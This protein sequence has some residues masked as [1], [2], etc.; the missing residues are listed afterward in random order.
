MLGLGLR[1]TP[2]GTKSYILVVFSEAPAANATIGMKN[3]VLR[4][5]LE[6]TAGAVT[7]VRRV[8]GD[9]VHRIVTVQPDGRQEVD[10][11]LP[12]SPDCGAAGAICTGAGG[13]LETPIL[14]RVR[15]PA[16]L[17]VADARVHE[18]PGATL[19]FAVTLGRA[20]S[21]TVV[22]ADALARIDELRPWNSKV[23]SALSEIV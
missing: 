10:I 15:G 2:A 3:R 22:V 1:V 14:T 23:D 19:A 18:G 12:A 17:T 8:N 20:T 6:V 5:A 16:G 9:G 21:A 13:R 11:A 4:N 7:R